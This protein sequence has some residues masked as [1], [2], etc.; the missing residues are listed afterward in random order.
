MQGKAIIIVGA[1]GS[2]KTTICKR[3]L[4]NVH[5]SRLLIFDVNNEYADYLP[6]D[7]ELPDIDVFLDMAD[8]AR[9]RFI[10]FEEATVFFSNRGNN[11]KMRKI[12]V[13]KRH[14]ENI[15]VLNFHSIRAI[16]H[17]IYDLVNYVFV[18]KT[19]DS[20]TLVRTK[21]ELLLPAFLKVRAM[22]PTRYPNVSGEIVKIA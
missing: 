2:G 3:L 12:L 17:Y 5:E 6:D 19:N 11:A 15:I 1:T 14:N 16:P 21:H 7:Y 8:N 18:L 9:G 10:L 13:A 4:A 22:P 20:E